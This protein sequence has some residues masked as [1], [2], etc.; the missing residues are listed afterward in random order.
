MVDI[1]G[2]E[3]RRACKKAPALTTANRP[4]RVSQNGIIS[5]YSSKNP[6]FL[7]THYTKTYGNNTL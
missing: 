6:K 2:F 7:R 5:Q 1:E 4:K 3:P